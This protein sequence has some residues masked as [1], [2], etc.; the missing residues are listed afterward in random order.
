MIPPNG[1]KMMQIDSSNY[2]EVV[3]SIPRPMYHELH[4]LTGYHVETFQWLLFR[5]GEQLK[6]SHKV[7]IDSFVYIHMYPRTHQSRSI[8]QRSNSYIATK[9]LPAIKLMANIFNEIH[10]EER[11][12][13][14]N[15]TP[16]FPYYVNSIVDTFPIYVSKPTNSS[17]AR[18]LYNPKYGGCVWKVLIVISFLGTIVYLRAPFPGTVYDGHIWQ[19]TMSERPRLP[20]ELTLGDAH[21][22]T[23][24]DVMTQYTH[25]TI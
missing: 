18:E 24:P 22:V 7:F 17:F 10:W 14:Y 5:Y 9:I 11:L 16:H 15:H 1:I 20:G 2:K 4:A 23:C 13:S 8:F 25:S 12:N 19:D 21:F 3:I 6:L